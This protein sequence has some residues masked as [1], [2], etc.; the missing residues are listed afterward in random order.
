MGNRK[1]R[2][3]VGKVT[4]CK[5]TAPMK[6][7]SYVLR[8]PNILPSGLVRSL[9][10]GSALSDLNNGEIARKEISTGRVT[11]SLAKLIW[12]STGMTKAK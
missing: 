6:V 9:Q 8:W 7:P 5:I 1:N 4:K 11:E 3:I 2:K 12:S 10:S